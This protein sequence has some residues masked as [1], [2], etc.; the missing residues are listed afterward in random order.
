[1]TSVNNSNSSF[2]RIRGFDFKNNLCHNAG[3]RTVNASLVNVVGNTFENGVIRISSGCADLN[4]IDNII[5]GGK[6]FNDDNTDAVNIVK[7]NNSCD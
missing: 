3:I 2:Y 7:E 5:T 1:M 6:C 4:F